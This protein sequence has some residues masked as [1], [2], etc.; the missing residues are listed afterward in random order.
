MTPVRSLSRFILAMAIGLAGVAQ[1]GG[2]LPDTREDDFAHVCRGGTNAG[3]PC[4][5]PTEATDCPA[6]E[7]VVDAV[8][9]LIRGT[10]TLIAHD[11]V[12][13][14]STGQAGNQALTLLLEL[15]GPAG[16][17]ELLAAT[18]QDLALPTNPP[19]APGQVV[20]LPMDEGGLQE[21]ASGVSGLLY[22]QPESALA[23]HLRTLFGSTGTPALVLTD[24]RVQLADHRGD[25][26]ATVVRFKMRMQF[27][28]PGL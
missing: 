4:T 3:L 20:V 5:V 15:R 9:N 13:D 24:R 1:A 18:Y 12:T 25:A 6:S 8:S 21:L 27:L 19:T 28:T 10:L 23:D 11:A 22:V 14:W 26:L 16:T 7:C 2:P 17:R